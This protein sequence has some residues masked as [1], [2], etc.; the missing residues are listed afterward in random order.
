MR[1]ILLFSLVVLSACQTWPPKSAF[2]SHRYDEA[3]AVCQK[4]VKENPT[5]KDYAY[6]R[7]FLASV[8]FN[9]GKYEEAN[10]VLREALKVMERD[11][12]SVV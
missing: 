11:R 7:L 10:R 12:K 2:Y 4:Q 8:A 6:H 5:G 1:Y 9:A 3:F